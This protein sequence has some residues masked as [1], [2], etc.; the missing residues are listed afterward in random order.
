MLVMLTQYEK[1]VRY[2]HGVPQVTAWW[3]WWGGAIIKSLV[4]NDETKFKILTF[5][6]Y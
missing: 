4:T 3:W 2:S 6:T 5:W 1:L